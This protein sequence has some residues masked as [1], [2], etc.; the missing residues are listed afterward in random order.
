MRNLTDNRKYKDSKQNIVAVQIA[1]KLS[2]CGSQT[3]RQVKQWSVHW[4]IEKNFE[5][6]LVDFVKK[7]KELPYI[8]L[9]LDKIVSLP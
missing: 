4:H 7:N 9:P 1:S 8:T 5:N 6:K 3:L 2:V